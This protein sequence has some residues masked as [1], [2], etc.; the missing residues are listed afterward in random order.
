VYFKTYPQFTDDPAWTWS[1]L[2]LVPSYLQ[3][4]V[5]MDSKVRK[6]TSTEENLYDSTGY[7]GV[8]EVWDAELGLMSNGLDAMM[9]W[10][11]V[12]KNNATYA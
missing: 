11:G 12:G 5:V 1:G 9:V 2:F 8:R 4:V 10:H 6:L 3:T 7:D